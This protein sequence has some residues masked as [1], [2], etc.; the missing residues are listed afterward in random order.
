[1][2]D[3]VG[4]SEIE[5]KLLSICYHKIMAIV[6]QLILQ[7]NSQTWKQIMKIKEQ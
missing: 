1:M 6:M 4:D 5:K 3:Q 2:L 7:I